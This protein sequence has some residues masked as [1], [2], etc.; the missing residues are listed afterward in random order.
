MN[1][2]NAHEWL[3]VECS[4]DSRVELVVLCGQRPTR[5]LLDFV[6]D[7]LLAKLTWLEGQ[8]EESEGSK[9]HE[10]LSNGGSQLS[11]RYNVVK[12]P[13]E[14]AIIVNVDGKN[15]PD[16]YCPPPALAVHKRASQL[17][18]LRWM[19][20]SVSKGFDIAMKT[21]SS[22]RFKRYPTTYRWV[23]SQLPFTVD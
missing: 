18:N 22:R 11:P 3:F 4:G 17:S 23:S 7:N 15:S 5:A 14:A 16:F 9:H 1:D 12:A 13:E 10:Q 20:N 6:G 2:D 19:P 21:G 8:Y